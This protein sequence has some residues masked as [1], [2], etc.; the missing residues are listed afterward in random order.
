MEITLGSVRDDGRVSLHGAGAK[1]KSKATPFRP[2]VRYAGG[3]PLLLHCTR[4]NRLTHSAGGGAVRAKAAPALKRAGV[5]SEVLHVAVS[6]GGAWAAVVDSR[7]VL[8]LWDLLRNAAQAVDP[9]ASPL[10]DGMGGLPLSAHSKGRP[11]RAASWSRSKSKSKAAA[12][13]EATTDEITAV[14]ISDDG[15][16]IA[17]STSASGDDSGAGG[18]WVWR[19]RPAWSSAAAARTDEGT[20][21]DVASRVGQTASVTDRGKP[22][23][24]GPRD[25]GAS[26]GDEEVK[27]ADEV[28]DTEEAAAAAAAA[29]QAAAS[30]DGQGIWV[31]VQIGD[32]IDAADGI[33]EVLASLSPMK[34][35]A[36]TPKALP[37]PGHLT[38][39][40]ADDDSTGSR[41]L[42]FGATVD[43]SRSTSSPPMLVMTQW[44][45]ELPPSVSAA[46]AAASA[47]GGNVVPTAVAAGDGSGSAQAATYAFELD[48]PA[49]RYVPRVA[50]DDADGGDSGGGGERFGFH[51]LVA[52]YDGVGSVVAVAVNDVPPLH[53]SVVLYTPA[54]RTAISLSLGPLLRR[55][56][57]LSEL[58]DSSDASRRGRWV[59][60]MDWCCAGMLLA[61]L[62]GTGHVALFSRTG[63]VVSLRPDPQLS[64]LLSW[65]PA[66]ADVAGLP[67]HVAAEARDAARRS[68][69][70]DAARRPSRGRRG[71]GASSQRVA[72]L[73]PRLGASPVLVP[74]L[75]QPALP[76][77]L[78]N[79]KVAAAKALAATCTSMSLR[80]HPGGRRVLV[81]DGLRIMELR[82]PTTLVAPTLPPPP[83]F[84]YSLI[85]AVARRDGAATAALERASSANALGDDDS[86]PLHG[87]SGSLSALDTATVGGSPRTAPVSLGAAGGGGAGKSAWS[88]ASLHAVAVL[89]RTLSALTPR[90]SAAGSGSSEDSRSSGSVVEAL[91]SPGVVPPGGVWGGNVTTGGL[92]L[93]P[94]E[95]ALATTGASGVLAIDVAAWEARAVASSGLSRCSASASTLRALSAMV[96][97]LVGRPF[98]GEG[99]A[100]RDEGVPGALN[101][102]LEGAA[103]RTAAAPVN[104]V[105]LP[106]PVWLPG[107]SLA[108]VGL[109]VAQP[110]PWGTAVS[111]GAMRVALRDAA[112]AIA[113]AGVGADTEDA[114]LADAEAARVMRK[115]AAGSPASRSRRRRDDSDDSESDDDDSDDD[116]AAGSSAVTTRGALLGK[117]LLTGGLGSVQAHRAAL[118]TMRQWNVSGCG[119]VAVAE[120]TSEVV[121]R[122]CRAGA[123]GA[124]AAVVVDTRQLVGA[125]YPLNGRAA[126]TSQRPVAPRAAL[127]AAGA[128]FGNIDVEEQTAIETGVLFEREWLAIGLA[129]L[130]YRE[131]LVRRRAGAMRASASSGDQV[132]QTG[133]DDEDGAEAEHR[134][135]EAAAIG[136]GVL[137]FVLSESDDPDAVPPGWKNLSRRDWLRH[138]GSVLPSV[139]DDERR[140]ADS[141]AAVSDG[142]ARDDDKFLSDPLQ[143]RKPVSDRG[144]ALGTTVGNLASARDVAGA[145]R[146]LWR[147]HV[148]SMLQ[149]ASDGAADGDAGSTQ[150]GA[151]LASARRLYASVGSCS[152]PAAVALALAR[153]DVVRAIR[154]VHLAV[155]QYLPRHARGRSGSSVGSP[156]GEGS[157]GEH[158]AHPWSAALAMADL[159][160]EHSALLDVLRD[161]DADA[162]DQD[163]GATQ[164]KRFHATRRETRAAAALLGRAIADYF[165][166]LTDALLAEHATSSDSARF[167]SFGDADPLQHLALLVP[168]PWHA[169]DA[170]DGEHPDP[171]KRRA[172]VRRSTRRGSALPEAA[173]FM[174]RGDWWDVPVGPLAQAASRCDEWRPATAVALL[175]AADKP[176]EAAAVVALVARWHRSD[177]VA[178]ALRN[179]SINPGTAAL[180][181][182]VAAAMKG[183]A[184]SAWVAGTGSAHTPSDTQLVVPAPPLERPFR[185]SL[186]RLL[187]IR[188]R[189]AVAATDRTAL[190]AMLDE[191]SVR[192]GPAGA[193]ALHISALHDAVARARSLVATLPLLRTDRCVV[194]ASKVGQLKFSDWV[195]AS[196]RRCVAPRQWDG[197]AGLEPTELLSIVQ[198]AS[199][200]A[201]AAASAAATAGGRAVGVGE[202]PLTRGEREV[203][204]AKADAAELTARGRTAVAVRAVFDQFAVLRGVVQ[205]TADVGP[206]AGRAADVGQRDAAASP[207]DRARAVAVL[208]AGLADDEVVDAVG[209]GGALTELMRAV[210]EDPVAD[211]GCDDEAAEQR[212]SAALS[213]CFDVLDACAQ[214]AGTSLASLLAAAA[215]VSPPRATDA[216]ME[217]RPRTRTNR[218]AV[219]ASE[220]LAAACHAV[221]KDV[222]AAC[223]NAGALLPATRSLLLLLW[224]RHARDCASAW[225]QLLDASSRLANGTASVFGSD[226]EE[227]AAR[228]ASAAACRLAQLG[229]TTH[230]ATHAVKSAQGTALALLSESGRWAPAVASWAISLHIAPRLAPGLARRSRDA[231]A[232]FGGTSSQHTPSMSGLARAQS[233]LSLAASLCGL[234]AAVPNDVGAT[235]SEDDRDGGRGVGAWQRWVEAETARVEEAVA[236]RAT[237][238]RRWAARVRGGSAEL[239]EEAVVQAAAAAA[240]AR[241][242]DDGP[243]VEPDIVSVFPVEAFAV[244]MCDAEFVA[245]AHCTSWV[246]RLGLVATLTGAGDA[247][248]A[249]A[250][251]ASP[252]PTSL[253]ENLLGGGSSGSPG[254]AST[255]RAASERKARLASVVDASVRLDRGRRLVAPSSRTGEAFAAAV[256]THGFSQRPLGVGTAIPRPASPVAVIEQQL[257]THE[258][259]AERVVREV[260]QRHAVGVARTLDAAAPDKSAAERA[261]LPR[262]P[263]AILREAHLAV[264]TEHAVRAGDTLGQ[265]KQR[266]GGDTGLP[267]PK[268]RGDGEHAD[269]AA[270]TLLQAAS[271]VGRAAA[272]AP[273]EITVDVT[274]PMV[275][276]RHLLAPAERAK[277]TAAKTRAANAEAES[278]AAS[279]ALAIA[280]AEAEEA[281]AEATRAAQ[282]AAA[283][284]ADAARR[285]AEDEERRH[286]RITF[287][288]SIEPVAAPAPHDEMVAKAE[289]EAKAD[290]A[291]DAAAEAEAKAAADAATAE[292]ALQSS[293]DA[294]AAVDGDGVEPAK[295]RHRHKHKH[296]HGHKRKHGHKHKHKRKHKREHKHK[297]TERGDHGEAAVRKPE[298]SRQLAGDDGSGVPNSRELHRRVR[299]SRRAP[300]RTST[301]HARTHR[302]GVM[303]D[304]RYVVGRGDGAVDDEATQSQPPQWGRAYYPSHSPI[305]ERGVGAPRERCSEPSGPTDA[306]TLD[307]S[308]PE[309]F[310]S[311]APPADRDP[312]GEVPVLSLDPEPGK[313][314]TFARA[315]SRS[316]RA[317]SEC[318]GA[319]QPSLATV[320]GFDVYSHLGD[321]WARRRDWGPQLP[322][323]PSAAEVGH[324]TRSGRAASPNAEGSTRA[325]SPLV[326]QPVAP[327]KAAS[328]PEAAESPLLA[329]ALPSVPSE[330]AAPVP[331]IADAGPALT[332]GAPPKAARGAVAWDDGDD[333]TKTAGAPSAAKVVS[334]E[335]QTD[336]PAASDDLT[337][338]TTGASTAAASPP[339]TPRRS[340]G[341]SPP[342]TSTKDASTSPPGTPVAYAAVQADGD[343]GAAGPVGGG[344]SPRSRGSTERDDR[345]VKPVTSGPSGADGVAGV[346]SASDPTEA[347]AMAADQDAAGRVPSTDVTGAAPA[348]ASAT[349]LPVAAAAGDQSQLHA[350]GVPE[351]LAPAAPVWLQGGIQVHVPPDPGA[352]AAAGARPY[353]EDSVYVSPD[354]ATMLAAPGGVLAPAS[355]GASGPGV[356]MLHAVDLPASRNPFAGAAA[357]G[358][359]DAAGRGGGGGGEPVASRGDDD[360]SAN[361]A[362]PASEAKAAAGTRPS[363]QRPDSRSAPPKEVVREMMGQAEL[364]GIKE[365]PFEDIY[366][367]AS[368]DD[369]YIAAAKADEEEE[370]AAVLRP[371]TSPVDVAAA[372]GSTRVGLVSERM[373]AMD[374]NLSEIAKAAKRLEDDLGDTHV[375]LDEWEADEQARRVQQLRRRADALDAQFGDVGRA[376]DTGGSN[377]TV[378]PDEPVVAAPLPSRAHALQ[379]ALEAARAASAE[380][381]A[382]TAPPPQGAG[383]Y[384]DTGTWGIGGARTGS[385]REGAGVDGDAEAAEAARELAEARAIMAA[386]DAEFAA[387]GTAVAD[388]DGAFAGAGSASPPVR[389]FAEPIDL[390]AA[391]QRRRPQQPRA[392]TLDERGGP[393]P[394]Q[395]RRT[396]QRR[397]RQGPRFAHAVGQPQRTRDVSP[398]ANADAGVDDDGGTSG[399]RPAPPGEVGESA[400]RATAAAVASTTRAPAA[401]AT[402]MAEDQL[403]RAEES[404]AGPPEA[405][406]APAEV[407]VEAPST[408]RVREPLVHMSSPPQRPPEE[409]APSSGKPTDAQDAVTHGDA[410]DGVSV[411]DDAPPEDAGVAALQH[412]AGVVVAAEK[413]LSPPR[414]TRRMG[415]PVAAKRRTRA[416]AA[417][418]RALAAEQA[419]TS[420]EAER[421]ARQ[422]AARLGDALSTLDTNLQSREP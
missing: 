136:R 137:E 294:S 349:T 298:A 97:A 225:A 101:P 244:A 156:H 164:H 108:A 4:T 222:E 376:P 219:A 228:H 259:T 300:E 231:I 28:V 115:A 391:R 398:D 375:E 332:D 18:L 85:S 29:A 148:V 50:D 287:S 122:L 19:K 409:P 77:T 241:D 40:F 43:P 253:A 272:G 172:F 299:E 74:A 405:E 260:E 297:H 178:A 416:E 354:L 65:E 51:R 113:E 410:E 66:S 389:P 380:L 176:T 181:R 227:D 326:V 154:V 369:G 103:S 418:R 160:Q 394:T 82:L 9:P 383:D 328:L 343:S 345:V 107:G 209:T 278:A 183:D 186:R 288:D 339:R 335:V 120:L 355:M 353:V 126:L 279:T 356:V 320:D 207:T 204:V 44:S 200:A 370:V 14:H 384:E 25:G 377:A 318:G 109:A 62:T 275:Q 240:D 291:A 421:A 90:D 26:D 397:R 401:L 337:A 87:L 76:P 323:M 153:H 307:G 124:A 229:S 413:A 48:F 230:V 71:R 22:N 266:Y 257:A 271:G 420:R 387:A 194:A 415:D 11:G 330:D 151:G 336:S 261:A 94:R 157:A 407:S 351:P 152:A 226:E 144:N 92:G 59:T 232:T 331:P 84:E 123:F 404:P 49:Y 198:A 208:Y 324:D 58:D 57:G 327:P 378:D 419:R 191:S 138:R 39:R 236:A 125:A 206:A 273:S 346:A 400:T 399:T 246:A 184:P 63:M 55:E 33:S 73:A 359:A 338:A 41:L 368:D 182:H 254:D 360:S 274:N 361:E 5:A 168:S 169:V 161:D 402:T 196:L 189:D 321:P 304:A 89:G 56:M 99:V 121:Q 205:S 289:A 422:L 386:L 362:T 155:Q 70:V 197:Q 217:A 105:S 347:A 8:W 310:L 1:A 373:A 239:D 308:V 285:E 6:R 258:A 367:G 342:A 213:V 88:R 325:V 313:T 185:K 119:V 281:E 352:V 53:Q 10:L 417:R 365:P 86:H 216:R 412:A 95:G 234:R 140:E 79:K 414:R 81:S 340:I 276:P 306:A 406:E 374:R 268:L 180:R 42:L 68:A 150:V 75:V 17:V 221:A 175:L 20:L 141:S 165:M 187:R 267:R 146:R 282:E 293:R 315:R 34:A 296:K 382:A 149:D 132:I 283:A 116:G 393:R 319:P 214:R 235:V 392:A 35:A 263:D 36:P 348:H 134:G 23:A 284:L 147:A 64:R 15:G 381:A 7:R 158:H 114:V 163:G 139:P 237:A 166:I 403:E 357:E 171:L 45:C 174:S 162:T 13:A 54:T 269:A 238:L 396:A 314:D 16:A 173:P 201:A 167:G 366:A 102:T 31:C 280:E 264:S 312:W 212:C 245:F 215:C 305:N 292:S 46:A 317:L 170:L 24:P 363:A 203:A 233:A 188:C 129:A 104:D 27:E 334:A 301:V 250:A 130:E 193:A 411:V 106:L 388:T 395:P 265:L 199:S 32:D 251:I 262:D 218:E 133:R 223:E 364:M 80:A 341:T 210:A 379:Q 12:A 143:G 333:A 195:P 145:G 177:R 408:P 111:Q 311:L 371:V 256:A 295:H 242:A 270:G 286:R 128:S 110:V 83:R 21:G 303:V 390:R 249:Y 72:Q 192:V 3:F 159:F 316:Q 98:P 96:S 350:R 290:V 112:N 247:A 344:P 38:S 100:L 190:A 252:P 220:S 202:Q 91:P 67:L 61:V 60:A 329:D 248:G 309:G 142:A 179:P 322:D 78:S 135:N 37:F 372:E 117:L 93:A 224:A 2:H 211:V 118:R 69:A 243:Y 302:S 385:T 358:A 277:I 52:A 127:E 255:K 47:A 30:V 131:G